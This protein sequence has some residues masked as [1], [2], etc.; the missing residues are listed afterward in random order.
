MA[1][2]EDLD[3]GQKSVD[4]G[5][6]N[7]AGSQTGGDKQG[8]FDAAKLQSALEA[9]TKRLD[10]VDARSKSLQGDKDRGVAKTT[11]EVDELKKKIAELE[12][13]RKAG[14]DDETAWE[15]MSFRES[16]MSLK[17]Q[18]AKLN[19]VPAGNGAVDVAKVF[20]ELELPVNAET[21]AL[22]LKHYASADEAYATAAKYLAS[23]K[24]KPTPSAADA[25]TPQAQPASSPKLTEEGY[26]KE[27][28]AIPRG[29]KGKEAR[30]ALQKKYAE[31]GVN[32]YAVDLT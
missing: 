17:E 22:K 8:S 1:E 28:K 30:D 7:P 9:F 21:E 18:I 29:P 5:T 11:K 31:G 27:W 23:Q 24:S 2:I 20:S 32:I 13:F 12:K 26:K 14:Y 10:E 6:T 19:S 15:E 16:V 25:P 3:S 4:G